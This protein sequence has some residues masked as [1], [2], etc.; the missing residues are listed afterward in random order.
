MSKTKI[1]SQSNT[2]GASSINS[3]NTDATRI[4]ASQKT[5]S[6]GLDG[7]LLK[8]QVSGLNDYPGYLQN[9]MDR[10][11]NITSANPGIQNDEIIRNRLGH[12][13]DWRAILRISPLTNIKY[14]ERSYSMLGRSGVRTADN[15]AQAIASQNRNNTTAYDAGS[16]FLSVLTEIGGI[17]FPY[18]PTINVSSKVNWQKQSIVHSNIS[19]YS[20][21][22]TEPETFDITGEFTAANPSEALYCLAIFNFLRTI[23]KGSGPNFDRNNRTQNDMSLN[24]YSGSTSGMT[25]EIPGAPPPTLYFSAYGD[26]MINEVPVVVDSYS[27]TLDKEVDYVEIVLDPTNYWQ[28]VF[29]EEI[30]NRSNNKKALENDYVISRVPTKF[31]LSMKLNTNINPAKYREFSLWDYKNGEYLRKNNH[32]GYRYPSGW[33]W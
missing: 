6:W 24:R 33:T 29:D 32:G 18:T 8:T 17:L 16:G 14:S 2:A 21:Q 25:R 4:N 30:T 15:E 27:Y 3:G 19:Y 23:T 9:S 12:Y 31:T 26:A 20:W 10:K 7:N 28:P 5:S 1:Y 11:I 22:N 13:Q